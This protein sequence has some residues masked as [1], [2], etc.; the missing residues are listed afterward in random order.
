MSFLLTFLLQL[1]SHLAFL[2]S[3]FCKVK[4]TFALVASGE[5]SGFG[6]Y[7]SHQEICEVRFYGGFY[8]AELERI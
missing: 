6:A 8:G 3:Q 7:L 4:L 1:A 5:V 2:L